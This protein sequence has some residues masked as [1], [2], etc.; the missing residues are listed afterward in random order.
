MPELLKL[1][2]KS[3]EK[4]DRGK[5][6]FEDG[7]DFQYYRTYRVAYLFNWCLSSA[8]CKNTEGRKA[9]AVPVLVKFILWWEKWS[10]CK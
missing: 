1:K 6:A 9:D 5:D 7:T 3:Q 8:R 2:M 4:F 10:C